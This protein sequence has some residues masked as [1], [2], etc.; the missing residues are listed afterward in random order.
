MAF[1]GVV[2]GRLVAA[3]L[4]LALMLAPLDEVTTFLTK[5]NADRFFL[6]SVIAMFVVVS[7]VGTRIVLRCG[8]LPANDELFN[9][10]ELTPAQA[11]ALRGGDARITRDAPSAG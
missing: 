3:A 7:I 2:D 4:L 1:G 9:M 11:S 6:F 8:E 10:H 5:H